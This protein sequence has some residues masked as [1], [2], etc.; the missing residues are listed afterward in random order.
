MYKFDNLRKTHLSINAA[1]EE[2]V[3]QLFDEFYSAMGK[4]QRFRRSPGIEAIAELEDGRVIGIQAKV[5]EK[6]DLQTRDNIKQIIKSIK[7]TKTHFP[8]VKTWILAIP[9]TPTRVDRKRWQEEIIDQHPDLEFEI[10][11]EAKLS[12]LLVQFR[13]YA[14][15]WFEGYLDVESFIYNSKSNMERI[16]YSKKIHTVPELERNIKAIIEQHMP[17][18]YQSWISQCEQITIKWKGHFDSINRLIEEVSEV[19]NSQWDEAQESPSIVL[20]NH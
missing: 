18:Y 14:L 10:W 5:F 1:F 8:Q 11:G 15:F 7:T 16:T 12:Q 20:F 2:M 9:F 17:Q 6:K 13:S 3:C 4:V 19:I